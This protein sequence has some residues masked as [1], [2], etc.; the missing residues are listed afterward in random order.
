MEH[1]REEKSA[2]EQELETATTRLQHLV[3]KKSWVSIPKKD[4]EIGVGGFGTVHRGVLRKNMFAPKIVVAVKKLHTTGERDKR[5]RVALELVRELTVQST[6]DHPNILPLLGFHLSHDLGEAWLIS[7]YAPNGNIADYLEKADPPVSLEKRLEM[8]NDTA[9]GLEY[10]H[11]RTP[12]VCHGDIKSV[13][14]CSLLY[15]AQNDELPSKLN[16]LVRVD[17][18]AMLCDFGLSKS[19]EGMTATSN[20]NDGGTTRYRCPELFQQGSRPTLESD[21]WA[22]GCLL[23]EIVTSL[24][25]Y[26]EVGNLEGRVI[27]QITEKIL[28]AQTEKLSCPPH[29][30]NLLDQCWQ[31]L[32]EKRPKMPEVVRLLEEGNR[33]V[34]QQ[35]TVS[36]SVVRPDTRI[37]VLEGELVRLAQQIDTCADHLRPLE[38]YRIR[39][40][41]L[42]FLQ[43]PL[44]GSGGYGTIHKASMRQGTFGNPVAVVAVKKLKAGGGRDK[45]VRMA[46][47]LIRELGVWAGLSHE[48]LIPLIGF[49]LN[50]SRDQAWLISPYMEKGNISDYL[51]RVQPDEQKRRELV[52]D[53][54]RGLQHLHTR[55]PPICHGDIK[56]LNVLI[57]DEHR[58]ML[59]DFGLAKAMENMPSGLTTSTFNQGG[60][61]P[62]E[63]PE[64]LRGGS[65]RSP[66]SDVWAWGC[67]AQEILSGKAPYYWANN[68]GAIVK[69]ITQDIPPAAA[70]DLNCPETYFRRHYLTTMGLA[71]PTMDAN[72]AA[73]ELE[74]PGD[75]LPDRARVL[76][77]SDLSFNEDS[78]IGSGCVGVVFKTSLVV[79]PARNTVVAVKLL[80]KPKDPDASDR[81]SLVVQAKADRWSTFGHP[82][83]L[84]ITGYSQAENKAHKASLDIL[85]VFP[86]V[87][88]KSIVDYIEVR[89]PNY[90]QRMKL[91]TDV[92][93][94]LLYLHSRAP[95]I[96]HG[97]LHT[98]NI[99]VDNQGNAIL[100]DYDLD[101]IISQVEE[102]VVAET[103]RYRSPEH[104]AKNTELTLRSDVWCLGSVFLLIITDRIP[105]SSFADEPALVEG[106]SQR[107]TPVN[108]DELDCPPRAQN[109]LGLCWKWEPETRASLSEIIAILSGRLCKFTEAW[110]IPAAS[111]DCLRFSQD[112]KYLI[113][114][115]SEVGL[116][117][118]EVE[119]GTVA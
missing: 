19:E 59:C 67:L 20:T 96:R 106:L 37:D 46:I 81:L 73:E 18:R 111:L 13:R 11:T 12:P 114:G 35:G 31:T 75:P 84:T 80:F 54:A 118:Y 115:V 52:L 45:R 68:G 63:S 30:R 104:L 10:L 51:T 88:N 71:D 8:A 4:S 98:S 112:G 39:P 100:C 79:E 22:W 33:L 53:T 70:G 117:V 69:W 87:P 65:M 47:G 17:T 64:L 77:R 74:A 113:V 116:R 29:V 27:H 91:A 66:Q 48:N 40:A 3:M 21:V 119:T 109:I 101:E 38:R 57:T 97:N 103:F 25:P 16:V 42:L 56:A 78:R 1:S 36:T 76:K 83:V 49:H 99:L 93:Q 58:A 95:P 43:E 90:D 61:L 15:L 6:L 14:Q 7:P 60:T 105:Y 28:P 55:D 62:Y 50:S 89:T 23:L 32:P 26:H 9:K 102:H 85:L 44:V 94:G 86:Y 110:S 72:A 82:N 92:A 34:S 24:V 108:V 107:I 5:I 41:R 2:I